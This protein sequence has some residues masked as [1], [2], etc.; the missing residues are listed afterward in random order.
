MGSMWQLAAHTKATLCFLAGFQPGR[1][2]YC[3]KTFKRTFVASVDF[4]RFYIFYLQ[5]LTTRFSTLRLEARRNRTIG[6]IRLSGLICPS[7]MSKPIQLAIIIHDYLIEYVK[8]IKRI[9][10]L[11]WIKPLKRIKLA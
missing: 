9:E 6:L 2:S 7:G 1:E 11:K 4:W 3:F 5:P 10:P 8:Q